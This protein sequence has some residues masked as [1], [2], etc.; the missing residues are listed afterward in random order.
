MTGFGR[1][2]RNFGI[3]NFNA[4]PDVICFAKGV[5]SGYS[6]LGGIIVSN[7]IAEAFKKGT[8]KFTHGHTYSANP[9]SCAVGLKVMEIIKRDKLIQNAKEKGDLLLSTL[10][11]DME[12]IDIVG[13]ICGIGLQLGI[14]FVKDKKT[15]EPF[16]RH[17][18]LSQRITEVGLKKGIVVYPGSGNVDSIRGDNI[19]LTPPLI[20]SEEQVYEIVERLKETFIEVAREL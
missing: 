6:P 2:G 8:G 13:D 15:K 17:V 12:D 14:E 19:L 7:K 5:S 3:D 18:N 10:N 11:K 1:T 20:I 9:L 4:I 16:K